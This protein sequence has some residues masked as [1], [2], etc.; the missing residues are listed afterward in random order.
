[1]TTE[2]CS[3]HLN[4]NGGNLMQTQEPKTT[5]NRILVHLDDAVAEFGEIC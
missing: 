3:K 5:T 1:M 4:L 2:I